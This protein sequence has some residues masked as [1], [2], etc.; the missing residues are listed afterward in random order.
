MAA[1]FV[2]TSCSRRAPA[3]LVMVVLLLVA[4][5][6]GVF[7][8][9]QEDIGIRNPAV[10]W[11]QGN[12]GAALNGACYGIARVKMEFRRLELGKDR[13]LLAA[14]TPTETVDG[15]GRKMP[16][17]RQQMFAE[18]FVAL[19]Q[20][21]ALRNRDYTK[22]VF[23]AT[24]DPGEV[25]Q[26]LVDH[27]VSVEH[28]QLLILSNDQLVR[29]GKQDDT[30]SAEQKPKPQAHAVFVEG[31]EEDDD[32]IHYTIDDPN[33]KDPDTHRDVR[34]EVL[35]DKK[36]GTFLGLGAYDTIRHDTSELPEQ[37][38]KWLDALIQGATLPEKERYLPVWRGNQDQPL[39]DEEY[40]KEHHGNGLH[41]LEPPAPS[42]GLNKKLSALKTDEVGGV[43]LYF[44]PA[45]VSGE[46]DAPERW[47][48]VCKLTEQIT[49]GREN[50]LVQTP[51]LDQFEAVRLSTILA[52]AADH[53]QATLGGLTRVIGFAQQR[54]TGE[55]FLLGRV[56]P[57][58]K[59]IPLD[60]L[61]VALRAIWQ[62]GRTPAISLDPDPQDFFGPQ[63]VRIEDLPDTC[64]VTEFVRV[65]L[66]ADYAMKCIMLGN[67]ELNIAGFSSNY[68]LLAA[69]P[70]A[71]HAEY[72]RWWLCPGETTGASVYETTT[73]ELETCYFQSDVRVLTEAMKSEQG[74]LL[75]TGAQDALSEEAT[76]L[77]T[78][79]YAQIAEQRP[80]F[81]DLNAL[82]DVA[83]LA[84]VLRAKSIHSTALE[85]AAGRT[86]AK[87]VVKTSYQGIGPKILPTEVNG[88]QALLY[89]G[90][91]VQ[92]KTALRPGD[93]VPTEELIP[94][95]ELQQLTTEDAD[96]IA[97]AAMVPDTLS[98][99]PVQA[100]YID[101]EL[102]ANTAYNEVMTGD[103]TA[104]MARLN[105][106]I[107]AG[108]PSTR[109]RAV[110]SLAYMIDG[111][112]AAATRDIEVAMTSEPS[113]RAQRG[114]IR[115]YTGDKAGAL[116]DVQAAVKAYPDRPQVLGQKIWVNIFAGEWAGVEKDLAR[117]AAM[118]PLDPQL[119]TMRQQVR[120]LKRLDTNSADA[121]LH[122]LLVMP[123]GL[124]LDLQQVERLAKQGD[125][126]QASARMQAM[127]KQLKARKAAPN[128]TLYLE[129]RC[130]VRFAGLQ[131]ATGTVEG[132]KQARAYI[133]LLERRHPQW[134]IPLILHISFDPGMPAAEVMRLYDRACALPSADDPLLL[135]TQAQQDTDALSSL[136]MELVF[137]LG[138]ELDADPNLEIPPVRAFF[139]R[140]AAR[141]PEGP[142]KV[143]MQ[144]SAK[145]LDMLARE[146]N[147][148]APDKE[149]SA[150]L[151]QQFTAALLNAPPLPPHPN[152]I[153][154][155]ALEVFYLRAFE[156]AC[157][158]G[159]QGTDAANAD[160]FLS[161]LITT[162][163]ADWSS[164]AE[165]EKAAG[166][167]LQ[168]HATFAQT[169]KARLQAN[170][171]VAD[172]VKKLTEEHLNPEDAVTALDSAAEEMVAQLPDLTP[173]SKALLRSNLFALY[174]EI[175]GDAGNKELTE[176]AV[177]HEYQYLP[178]LTTTPTALVEYRTASLWCE[179]RF[180]TLTTQLPDQQQVAKI[181]AD[182]IRSG[183]RLKQQFGLKAAGQ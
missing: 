98:L 35:Y 112:Y 83:K 11:Q 78:A 169:L 135:E 77:F 131:A 54:K 158:H 97:L 41:I 33:V 57:D 60:L 171:D 85:Q 126:A 23:A 61:T 21:Y 29:R 3:F 34:K 138:S 90:G 22:E 140:V 161:Y 81:R 93:F 178:T 115:I 160:R 63:H 180:P 26:S 142:A 125:S 19:A 64:R 6:T 28:P 147:G 16:D 113:L 101:E 69:N 49:A 108:Q 92:L 174:A 89:I 176:K 68:D 40:Q 129:E 151:Q 45:I 137:Q 94:A 52:E 139:L 153:N 136:G 86:V 145:S 62:Q 7:A 107:A 123:I 70:Q 163:N 172:T 150:R 27:E 175:L 58:R 37:N 99:D 106:I 116:A 111:D 9:G 8:D 15:K 59:A 156:S 71:P 2:H 25:D 12:E 102:E 167:S 128:D 51:S 53:P 17:A 82:F 133:D 96:H 43:R 66:E 177:L 154:L 117:L 47:N 50:F 67:D 132:A 72:V 36:N 164:M 146:R 143:T 181:A 79:Y 173:F 134:I 144:L 87:V 39:S 114:R 88:E 127:L 120:L 104:G 4:S 42:G 5:A 122:S 183:A 1:L 100:S 157:R 103:R 13:S 20:N 130:W 148:K 110:R 46:E 44:D 75:G 149:E 91:G 31:R 166:H 76:R 65:M 118:T 179:Q 124:A 30:L 55:I 168:A 119:Q 170:P 141:M 121:F 95:D 165:L 155:Q 24:S 159:A 84:A 73:A 10:P 152:G 38:R 14:T 56:E 32:Y 182:Y 109:A 48:M 18:D 162:L 80:I 74:Q 105:R